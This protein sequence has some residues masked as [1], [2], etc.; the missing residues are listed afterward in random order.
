MIF[1]PAV[2]F[3]AHGSPLGVRTFLWIAAACAAVDLAL[4]FAVD[5][6]GRALAEGRKGAGGA[7]GGMRAQ[8][9]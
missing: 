4:V 9:A 2:A 8:P 3:L 7:G 5:A 1:P 6:G